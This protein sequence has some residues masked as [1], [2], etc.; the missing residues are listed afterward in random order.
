MIQPLRCNQSIIAHKRFTRSFHSLFSVCGERDVAC[1][2]MA[3]VEGPFCL[4]VADYEAPRDGHCA[5]NRVSGFCK[6]RVV[7]DITTLVLR[8]LRIS[9]EGVVWGTT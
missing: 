6:E 9:D 8:W 4:A 1:A 5:S 7:V 2:R 3:P